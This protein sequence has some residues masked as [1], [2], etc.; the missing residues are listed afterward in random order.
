MPAT[1]EYHGLRALEYAAQTGAQLMRRTPFGTD[2]PIAMHVAYVLWT[3]G[4]EDEVFCQAVDHAFV[5]AAES[6]GLS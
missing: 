6:A 5:A 1:T 4:V 3:L 2:E